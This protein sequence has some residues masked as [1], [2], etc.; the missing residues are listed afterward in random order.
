VRKLE[1]CEAFP[2]LALEGVGELRRYLDEIEAESI[3]RAKDLGA[4]SEDVAS[5]MG[6][7]RQGAHY[8]MRFSEHRLQRVRAL[9]EKRGEPPL[10]PIEPLTAPAASETV[11][12]SPRRPSADDGAGR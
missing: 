5:H 2:L 7:T 8:K 11:E 4:T 6:I 12:A 3:A 1:K 10:P 9:R